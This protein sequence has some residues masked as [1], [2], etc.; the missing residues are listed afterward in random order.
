MTVRRILVRVDW[1]LRLVFPR[2]G[3]S[4]GDDRSYRPGRA[5]SCCSAI[6]G[7]IQMRMCSSDLRRFSFRFKSD[8]METYHTIHTPYHYWRNQ[9]GEQGSIISTIFICPPPVRPPPTHTDAMQLT[10]PWFCAIIRWGKIQFNNTLFV[11][12]R[13]VMVALVLCCIRPLP[14]ALCQSALWNGFRALASSLLSTFHSISTGFIDFG[15][16]SLALLFNAVQIFVQF[17]V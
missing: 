12:V 6:E 4:V 3:W 8:H 17:G 5:N 2:A 16:K 13:M 1:K 10:L 15:K 14:F 11:M 7:S 9:G